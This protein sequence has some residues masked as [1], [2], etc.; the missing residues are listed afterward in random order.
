MSKMTPT[1]EVRAR[2]AELIHVVQVGEKLLKEAK[3][4]VEWFTTVRDV[5]Y[6]RRSLAM[7]LDQYNMEGAAIEQIPKRLLQIVP[8]R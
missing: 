3:M 4:N 5:D 6:L 2:I 1:P 8:S 7:Y